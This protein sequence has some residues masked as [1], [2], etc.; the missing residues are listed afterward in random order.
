M[1]LKIL[2][3]KLKEILTHRINFSLHTIFF[4]YTYNICTIKYVERTGFRP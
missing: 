3:I 2:I 1:L 4:Y